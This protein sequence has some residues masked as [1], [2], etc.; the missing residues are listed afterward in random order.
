MPVHFSDHEMT[1]R[2]ERLRA[3]MN[4]RDLEGLLLFN[5]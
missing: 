4:A 5:Q 3:A 1:A 2:M